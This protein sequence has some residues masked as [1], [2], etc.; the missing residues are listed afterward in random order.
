[1]K[2][3][4]NETSKVFVRRKKSTCGQIHRRNQREQHP[5]DSMTH[6]HGTFLPSFV[7]PI[8]LIC[9]VQSPYLVYLNI[10]SCVQMHLLAKMDSAKEAYAQ[11]SS[12]SITSL[13]TSKD[14]FAHVQSGRSP[15]LQNRK[16]VFSCLLSWQGPASPLDCPAIFILECLSWR[17]HLPPTSVAQQWNCTKYHK[18]VH[19]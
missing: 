10:L 4:S 2:T 12:V 17:H 19:F 9:L 16:Y 1:M 3:E 7:C 14:L 8:I 6:L 13:L 5:H 15:D 11:L 18:I